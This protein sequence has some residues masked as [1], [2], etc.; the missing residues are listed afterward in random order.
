MWYSKKDKSI[1]IL[2]QDDR[3]FKTLINN[4]SKPERNKFAYTFDDNEASSLAISGGKG[5]SLALLQSVSKKT[6]PSLEFYVPPGFILSVSA[7]DLQIQRNSI[8]KDAIMAVKQSAF[9]INSESLKKACNKYLIFIYV[10]K[11]LISTL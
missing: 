9:S 1:P 10:P 4:N 6:V 5:A 11:Q 3:K 7:L 8:L 2:I